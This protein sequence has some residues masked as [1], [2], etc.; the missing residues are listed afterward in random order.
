MFYDK[1]VALC[2]QKGI[3]VSRAAIDSGISKS[4]VTK[5]KTNKIDVPSSEVLYKLASYFGMSVSELL[6][7]QIPLSRESTL[8]KEEERILELFRSVP[9]NLRQ[10]MIGFLENVLKLS[11]N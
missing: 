11:N 5:W 3:S 1:F 8:T 9:G 7:E 2:K 4:L 6:E 10:E